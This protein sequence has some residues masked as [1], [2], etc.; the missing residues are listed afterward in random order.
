M[1]LCRRV[2]TSHDVIGSGVNHLFLMGGGAG[3]RISEPIYRQ[4]PNEHRAPW[5]KQRPPAT[6]TF[7]G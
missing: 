2:S 1:K 5:R 3:L 7:A 4:L 6:Y